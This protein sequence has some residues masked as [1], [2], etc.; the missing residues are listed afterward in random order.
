MENTIIRIGPDV[1]VNNFFGTDGN[2][3]GLGAVTVQGESLRNPSR[4]LTVTLD[5]PDGYLY[6]RFQLKKIVPLSSGGARLELTATARHQDR[7]EY[8][9]DFGQPV[10]WFE[11]FVEQV[12]DDLVLE[13]QPVSLKLAD[14]DWS[15]FSYR[16]LFQSK[17]RQI[18]RLLTHATWELGGRITGNTLLHQGQCNMPVYYGAKDTLFT[19]SCLRTLEQHG[20]PQGNSFQIA[21]RAGLLQAFDFQFSPTGALLQY[22]P[23]FD[24]VSSVLESPVG[25]DVLHVLD[26]YRFELTGEVATLAKHVLFAKGA[27]ADHDGRDLWWEAF[28]FVNGSIQQRFH[29]QES[30]VVPE[31]NLS[32][33][34]PSY[35]RE[36][37]LH[38]TICGEIVRHDQVPQAIAELVLPRLAKQGFKRFFPEPFTESDVTALGMIR[39]LDGGVHGDLHCSSL[40]GTHRYFPSEFWGGIKGWRVMADKAH[41][42]GME[43]GAWFAPHFS[44]RAPIF[45][46]H[47]EYQM[48]DV[49]G[50][51]SGGGYG[52][53]TIVVADWNSG[54]RE[55]VA[56]D[57]RR[58]HDE[59]GL[60][61]L[62]VDSYS[63]MGLLQQNYAQRFRT[64]F[65]AFGRL[66]ADLQQAG[67]R[68]FEFESV[69]AFG[70]GAFGLTDL[71]GGRLA[72]NKGVA[73]QND[74]GW[75]VGEEDMF[76]NCKSG[77]N[78]RFREASELEQ[79]QFK[80]LASRGCLIMQG[81]SGSD[82]TFP[83]WWVRL[84]HLYN[85]ALPYMTKGAHRRL[86]PD[87]A[88]VR[89]ESE[90]GT[91]YWTFKDVTAPPAATIVELDG[92]KL[93]P[94]QPAT[95]LAAWSV[96][97]AKLG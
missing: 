57:L 90:R 2:R 56:A 55:W 4:P 42:L 77:T 36:D 18:H 93:K 12:T 16:F 81:V 73:G 28:Q 65:A 5:T 30:I 8:F 44:P 83:A 7:G 61:Y 86:L 80:T 75:F 11:P 45:A 24:S 35:V 62:F 51:P 97:L 64:N 47:P 53:Q 71:R 26:E 94:C 92:E 33:Y 29:V 39:K 10:V 58:W 48:V 23:Q 32:H 31:T 17:S 20:K 54:I 22:W 3:L 59:G 43:F 19:S 70:Y 88:G 60:D 63:N 66:L 25:E 14:R 91:L 89:W 34:T 9:D 67:I 95:Q 15:G 46:E 37:G 87:G 27:V 76:F 72:Q 6:E 85:Q 96:Y 79:I 1:V 84:N 78:P 21:P 82:Y 52:F 49:C 68:S 40:C 50:F 74:F 13:L 41:S 38:F 69:S